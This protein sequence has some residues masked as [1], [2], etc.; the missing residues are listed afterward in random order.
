MLH[1]KTTRALSTEKCIAAA[2]TSVLVN[3]IAN[4]ISLN[5]HF[6]QEGFLIFLKEH[7]GDQMC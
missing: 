1:P 6:G 7:E 3:P 4:K 2:A 5:L